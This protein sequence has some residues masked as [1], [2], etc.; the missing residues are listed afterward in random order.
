MKKLISALLMT[1]MLFTMVSYAWAYSDDSKLVCANVKQISENSILLDR[2]DGKGEVNVKIDENTLYMD[3]GNAVEG[4]IKDIKLSDTVYVFYNEDK[5]N[6]IVYNIPQDTGCA[7]LHTIEKLEFYDGGQTKILTD[8][9]GMY[10][11]IDKNA[12][13]TNYSDGKQ[14]RETDLFVGQ[15]IFA[16]YDGVQESYPAQTSTYRLVLV[17][18][19]QTADILLDGKAI[20]TKAVLK[21]GVWTVPM[22]ETAETLGLEV[23]WNNDERIAAMENDKRK[24]AIRIGEDLYVSYASEQS[25]LIGM[26]APIKLGC[27]A[28][29]IDD[30]TWI[31]A[32]AFEIFVGFDV[33]QNN[34]TIQI[35][36]AS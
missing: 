14:I 33:T 2:I 3:S 1:V 24:M 28:Y 34:N 26:T 27:K 13:I 6:A 22:R 29:I 21:N 4:D 20:A 9:G 19:G 25:G 16:W 10:I 15:K 32:K 35:E 17:D 31:P 36:K 23:S 30:K 11:S 12:K 18:E 5:A 8:N 7:M